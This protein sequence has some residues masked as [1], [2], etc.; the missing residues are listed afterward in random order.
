M[1]SNVLFRCSHYVRRTG[2]MNTIGEKTGVG[3]SYVYRLD[4]FPLELE[5]MSTLNLM[6]PSK[7]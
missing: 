4:I 2:G 3:N 5:N 6:S 7:V 1:P